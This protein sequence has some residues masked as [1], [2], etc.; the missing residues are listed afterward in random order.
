MCV[1]RGAPV[2]CNSGGTAF[3]GQNMSAFQRLIFVGLTCS[4]L[5]D[6][7]RADTL[8]SDNFNSGASAA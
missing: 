2:G 8:F 1:D 4:S 7:A 6:L 5:V 3:R